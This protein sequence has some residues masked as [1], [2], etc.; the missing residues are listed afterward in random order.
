M[1]KLREFSETNTYHVILRGVNKQS[2][3]FDDEDYSTFLS[4]LENI[5][6]KLDI[7]I[8]TYTLM[9]NHIHLLVRVYGEY[10]ISNLVQRIC[11][12]YTRHYFNRKYKRVGSLFQSRFVSRVVKDDYDLITVMRYILLN[13]SKIGKN[14]FNYPYSSL[15]MTLS[16]YEN[17]T[18]LPFMG[19]SLIRQIISSSSRFISFLNEYDFSDIN[20]EDYLMDDDEVLSYLK[21]NAKIKNISKLV[22][23]ENCDITLRKLFTNLLENKVSINRIVRITNLPKKI[24]L[25]FI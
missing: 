19:T 23:I 13:P 22:R 21:V 14:A 9:S 7:K 2:T 24:V 5:S 20:D 11:I 3:F 6:K 10:T 12:S 16:S 15:N 8:I 17:N 1:R 4:I 25:S 18:D